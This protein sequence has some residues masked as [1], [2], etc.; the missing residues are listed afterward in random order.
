MERF[1]EYWNGPGAFRALPEPSRAAFVRAG[2]K[3]YQEVRSLMAD[4]TPAA[5]Y[6]AL[7]QPALFM[8]G[9][10]S[11]VAARHTCALLA[12]ALPR[13]TLRAFPGVGHMGPLT[14]AAL[15]NDAVAAH[16][17]AGGAPR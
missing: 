9:E 7:T 10:R 2:R 4:R 17:A 13:A 8:T 14:H 3:V 15:V 11:T 1:V 12:A 16:L 5:A 6:A